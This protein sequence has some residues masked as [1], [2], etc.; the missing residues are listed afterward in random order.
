MTNSRPVN[1]PPASGGNSPV[2]GPSDDGLWSEMF[3]PET[4]VAI[5][6]AKVPDDMQGSWADGVKTETRDILSLSS[7][8][9]L[10][11]AAVFV[12][13]SLLFPI[14]SAVVAEGVLVSN[15]RNKVLQH[16]TGGVVTDIAARDG[17]VVQA[18][19]SVLRLDP[20]NDQADLIRFK[21]R[22]AIL[23]AMRRRLEAEN[24]VAANAG[25]MP[26]EDFGLM[27]MRRG[28]DTMPAS[29]D[30]LQTGATGEADPL[31]AEQQRQ[32]E[33]GRGAADA[34]IDAMLARKD[35]LNRRREGIKERL[36]V[37]EAQVASLKRQ[38]GALQPAV[39]R[40][41]IAR[42]VLWDTEDQLL[43]RTSELANLKAENDALADDAGEIDSR[44]RQAKLTDQ[45]ETSMKLTEVLAEM[46]QI[47]GQMQAAEAAVRSADLRAPV[48]GT[49]VHS[50]HTTIGA[51]IAPGEVLA[52]IV[53]IGS[54]F[55]V[56]ARIAP[57]DITHVRTGQTARV[58]IA[59]L[60]ARIFD[61]IDALVTRVAA[62]TTADEKTGQYYFEVDLLLKQAAPAEQALLGPGMTAQVYIEGESRTFA[63]YVMVPFT[64]SLSRSFREP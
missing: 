9:L 8:G 25:R 55:A 64:D 29:I 61:D 47:S 22:F 3:R 10:A 18:G 28:F 63:D 12:F 11:G 38:T 33:R 51:V 62:D 43:A 23:D 58:K 17:E 20:V 16:R 41:H 14:G 60:N 34:E 30:D 52:E 59:A 44:I 35:A 26:T 42:K 24:A 54:D 15:G 19:A 46:R 57:H 5:A 50:K 13:W 1:M 31:L 49:V 40:G 37:M 45:R 39:D 56:K 53:P 2:P 4:P 27:D 21:A 32:F 36:G 7:R 6:A 48:T